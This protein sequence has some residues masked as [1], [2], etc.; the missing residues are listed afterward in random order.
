MVPVCF[1]TV[2][3]VTASADEIEE[4]AAGPSDLTT[5]SG[6]IAPPYTREDFAAGWPSVVYAHEV[7]GSNKPDPAEIEDELDEL[8]LLDPDLDPEQVTAILGDMLDDDG[9]Q[10]Q[11]GP[12]ATGYELHRKWGVNGLRDDAF[13]GSIDGQYQGRAAARLSNGNVVVVGN[14]VGSGVSTTKNLGIVR[15]NGRGQRVAWPNANVAFSLF[16]NQYLRFPGTDAWGDTRDVFDVHDVKVRGSDIYALI[17]MSDDEPGGGFHPA[18]IR[19]RDDGSFGGWWFATPDGATVRDA[20]AMDI[21]GS[22]MIV[23][24][25]RSLATT[26]LDGGFWTMRATINADGGL[27]IGA[28]TTFFTGTRRVPVDVAFRRV[29]TLVP[30]GGGSPSYYVA[31]SRNLGSTAD[32]DHDNCVARIGSNNALDTDFGGVSTGVSSL[33]AGESCPYFD[34]TGSVN[35]NNIDLA[36]AVQT[37]G[38]TTFAGGQLQGHESMYLLANVERVI[39]NGTGIANY[40]DGELDANFGPIGKRLYGGCAG[41]G[42]GEGCSAMPA[43]FRHSAHI[44]RAIYTTASPQGVYITGHRIGGLTTSDP[45]TRPMFM[46]VSATSGALRSIDVLGNVPN[47]L[48]ADLVPRSDT[49]EFTLAGWG[50]SSETSGSR[51]FLS[52]HVVR[53]SDLIFYDGLQTP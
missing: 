40:T 8:N 25:R 27:S 3:A 53:K 16:S 18:I 7:N 50:S 26:T 29:G 35:G 51:V 33:V 45:T 52:G 20:V 17:T 41:G 38:W 36:V 6:Y 19:F 12:T 1:M 11:G 44:P 31:Y 37:R 9:A 23:L 30:I 5:A 10:P 13:A 22:S 34:D 48:F 2:A 32:S 39:T 43:L 14:I 47:S 46:D 24:G 21:T 4:K 15:Y 28:I 49:G 42:V